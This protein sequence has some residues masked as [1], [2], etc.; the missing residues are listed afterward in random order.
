MKNARELDDFM[1][2]PSPALID[3]ISKIK[4]DIMVLGA[5]GKMGP[6]LCKLAANAIK[7]AGISKKIYAASRF[8]DASHAHDLTSHGIK[9][10]QTDLLNED[11]LGRLPHI[12]NIIYM[13]GRKFGTSDDQSLTW[14]MNSYLPGR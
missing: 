12:P 11:Q 2:R 7:E 1:C 9:V 4:G 10:F 6:T 8:S 13:A 3:D 14:V 5:G